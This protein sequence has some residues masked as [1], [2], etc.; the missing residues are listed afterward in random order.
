MKHL[1]PFFFLI[2]IPFCN[3]HAQATDT[4]FTQEWKAVDSLINKNSLPKT[5]LA[6]V[7]SIYREAKSRGLHAQVIKALL[8]R[9]S[10]EEKNT[11]T[12][13]DTTFS[14]W[15]KEIGNT[16]DTL[17]KSVLRVILAVTLENYFD[18]NE[19]RIA[20]RSETKNFKK[21]DI[22][23]WST[24]D[25]LKTIDSI[26]QQALKP[27]T[28][29]RQTG[30][31]QYDAV[32]L[33]GNVP[34]LRPTMYDL[35]A[36]MAIVF[37]T[38][39]AATLTQAENAFT[40]RD[41]N[42]LA[43]AEGFTHYQFITPDTSSFI[44]KTLHLYQ[45]IIRFHS[46][47][48]D[49]A[50]LV[51]ADINRIGWVYNN[52]AFSNKAKYYKQA[53]EAIT[54]KYPNHP[55]AAQAW[56]LLRNSEYN[57]TE[58]Y[59]PFGDTSR[60]YSL[61]NIRQELLQRL[62]AQP[63]ESEGNINMQGLLQQ[64]NAKE[65]TTKA[66][67]VN[68]PG[69]PFRM[70]VQF[71]NIDTLYGRIIN[72]KLVDAISKRNDSTFW[73]EVAT[74]PYSSSFIQPLPATGDYREHKVEIK[75]DG[76]PAGEYVLLG[77]S[78]KN[79]AD[80][81]GRLLTQDIIVSHLAYIHNGN[82]YYV[83]D[84]ESG[85]PLPGIKATAWISYYSNEKHV[86]FNGET[87]KAGHF[88]INN[89]RRSYNIITVKLTDGKDV[90]E[91][92]D[93]NYYYY[94]ETNTE[95]PGDDFERRN[96]IINFYTDRAIYRPG[97]KIFFKGIATTTDRFSHGPKLFIAKD[98]LKIY[99][100][101]VNGKSVDSITLRVNEYGSIAGSF[102]L[103]ANAL[104]GRF[105]I[106]VNGISGQAF[107][108]VE[109]Y[110][111]PTFYVQLDTL[112]SA[113]RLRDT[114]TVGGFAQAFAGNFLNNAQV[115]YNI[116]RRTRYIIYD[117]G[118]RRYP[119]K[120]A[121]QQIAEGTVTTDGSGKFTIRFPALP[122]ETADTS[123][124][125][126]FDFDIRTSVTDAGGE[127]R[128]ASTSLSV[129]YSSLV[130]KPGIPGIVTNTGLNKIPV[131]VENLSGR[132]VDANVH[133]S[134]SPLQ[135]PRRTLRKR[136]WDRPDMF[137][138]SR[139]EFI[140]NFPYDEYDNESD[141]H[142]W[143]KEAAIVNDTFTTGNG[144][145][146]LQHPPLQQGWY[147]IE[148][149][150]TDKDGHVIKSIVYTEVYDPS[151][152]IM[153]STDDNFTVAEKATLHPGENT[154]LLIGSGFSD[155]YVLTEADTLKQQA[156]PQSPIAVTL[157]KLDNS[158]KYIRRPVTESS[159]GGFGIYYA[160]VKHNRFYSGG[161]SF[162]VPFDNKQLNIQ[163]TTF[164]NKTEP[165]SKEQ[166]TI[167]VKGSNSANKA[168][169]LLT[170]MY[171]A[172]LD[173]FAENE[174]NTPNLWPE[175]SGNNT[176]NGNSGFNAKASL[177]NGQ[178]MQ[179][180][181]FY[182]S[183]PQL[184]KTGEELWY[185]SDYMNSTYLNIRLKPSSQS[186]NDVVVTGY[187]TARKKEVLGYYGARAPARML[188]GNVAGARVM[189]DTNQSLS[190]KNFYYKEGDM[191]I[192]TS[193]GEKQNNIDKNQ[194]LHLRTNFNET[195]FFFPQ[196]YPD[197]AGDYTIKFTMPE[198]LTKWKWM[199]LAH[200][201]DLAFGTAE[202]YII[203]QK[204]LMVQ[205]GMPRFLREG[206][207]LE[208]TARISNTGD[209]ALTGQAE[210]QLIDPLT[211]N[212]VDGLFHNVFSNQYF[213]AEA[214]QTTVV[215]FPVAIPFNYTKPL[216]Y[217]IIAST[218]SFNDG[219]E[220]TLP[221]LTNRLLVT[222]SLPLYLKGDTTKHF[223]FDKLLNNKSETLQT[224][225]LTVEYT[226]NPV[227]NAIQALPY[228]MEYPHECAEQTFNRFYANALAAY[229]VQ[230]HP[231]IKQVFDAWK[232]DTASLLSNLEK[233]QA[234][235]QVMLAETPWVLDAQNEAQQKKNIALLF[236]MVTMAENA[237]GALQKLQDM[238][239]DNGAFAWFKGGYADRYITQYI[240]TGIGR[241]QEIN[242]IPKNNTEVLNAMASK[243][244]SY[245]DA[246]AGSD[247]SRL[248]KNKADLTKD[249]LTQTAIQYL[250][251]RSYFTSITVADKKAYNYYYQQTMKY[252]Q[253][254]S[255]YMKGMIS[256]ALLRTN[257]LS[258]VQRNIYPSIIE[259][260][261]T[262]DEK[263]MY[264]KNNRW[265]Y[266]WYQSPIEQQALLIEL[267]EALHRKADAGEMRTWLINQK[268]TTNWKTTKATADACF[269]L[270]LNNSAMV[271]AN[272]T[273]T[274]QL[275]NYTVS[276]TGQTEAGTGYIKEVLPGDSV[277]ASMGNI[278]VSTQTPVAP[279]KNSSPSYGAVYWQYFEDMDKVTQAT[280]S[281]SIHKKLF[282]QNNTA[283]GTV[284]TPLDSDSVLHVGDRVVVRIELTTDR[285]LEYIHL[286]DMRAATMEPVNVLSEYK[287]Q[288]GL[289]YY[290]STKDVATDFFISYMPKGSYVF[291][292]PV[293]ITHVGTFS[294]G[295]ATVQC[296]YAPEFSSHSEGIKVM[297]E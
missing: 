122:D 82:D 272:R 134:I 96:A 277:A 140:K 167:Q 269:A 125:P 52:A 276:N 202:Q 152:E 45:N 151:N 222:E 141:P 216:T 204:T 159:R 61:V 220:N 246:E 146:T 178:P 65:L 120:N 250:F 248:I 95:T 34:T 251:M 193:M 288:D 119:Q 295:I 237:Q 19:W 105:S 207:E 286:K 252:W 278:T 147:A 136:Y 177:Q 185:N 128:E 113:Y 173:E 183:Y 80:T 191:I 154:S 266:Y 118:F 224:Q 186:L 75:M 287:W 184:A 109:E 43:P 209:T 236:D 256:M 231:R 94:S 263:G 22:S 1:L 50:A 262:T 92:N 148:A 66:E 163:Y 201:K 72:K 243:A 257:Q 247:Y 79:F 68:V 117:W 275:G 15:N 273:V 25:F 293:Y 21:S 51:D 218:A 38:S 41:T 284:L 88:S 26:Y 205:P 20:G 182:K 37:Y 121:T 53:L 115:K 150:T 142:T 101:D 89:A 7:N 227:W 14:T 197:S 28:L 235:K 139:E 90:Y 62:A 208:L 16:K 127:T 5:A 70:L 229:I 116:T 200:T 215:K 40:L 161:Q 31:H 279:V 158:K 244:L 3:I 126:I 179:G 138:M 143:Q 172:S 133:I 198:S 283:S 18:N 132:P 271:D 106:E 58:K 100:R 8:Y 187:G 166:W 111:R 91:S 217:R 285:D 86:A 64:I 188:E 162:S 84:R 99:L 27:V 181:F 234:L 190:N 296:M 297:V 165:G 160:F 264:W 289:G 11:E 93:N 83:V 33:K 137:V 54:Q 261:V 98:S 76:L 258:F 6:K 149:T 2:F 171:D 10:L 9:L 36:N 110:K 192:N 30:L 112:K 274:I 230:Q 270:L 23:T 199:S 124:N 35:L 17:Q 77:S 260:A 267:A 259:N 42:A 195:A 59:D 281:L 24:G 155:V 144:G 168:A 228:L 87:D 69:M 210:L 223:T 170:S 48:N 280:T 74:L 174:W 226:A 213:T 240:L 57:E 130:V 103:P 189:Y 249:N 294:G 253:N 156:Q 232:K 12:G 241:L 108:N 180:F 46:Q 39:R 4:T 63:A 153:P 214:G 255:E 44:L 13:I 211:G 29:L 81:A 212:P 55:Q 97:Q 60:R 157:V 85:K 169:E 104:T 135:S 242:A 292:Y 219:E 176:W 221:V 203:T 123:T 47:L 206:D 268:Q 67:S 225:S 233:N 291:E 56:Y 282:V 107:F 114:I 49:T 102:I 239:M 129:G 290:E 32:I 71:K 73:A 175:Y 78:I 265:G 196:L 245:L 131:S 164:R 238:Q 254:Q 194:S 145:Y